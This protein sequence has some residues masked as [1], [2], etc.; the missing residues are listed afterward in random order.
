M[1][2]A[3]QEKSHAAKW[4]T[5][6]SAIDAQRLVDGAHQVRS[7]HRD[8]VD[9]KRHKAAHEAAVAAASDIF[10]SQEPWRKAEKGMDRLATDVDCGKARRR[11]DNRLLGDHLTQAFQQ[12]RFPGSSATRYEEVALAGRKKGPSRRVFCGRRD[13]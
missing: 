5:R 2:I 7:H 1:Q 11:K 12:G 9:D 4:L 6:P 10:W 13:P 8:L 3:E